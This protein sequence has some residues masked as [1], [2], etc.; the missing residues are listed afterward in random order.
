M[1]I[2]LKSQGRKQPLDQVRRRKALYL[3]GAALTALM[4][5]MA[6]MSP[7]LAKE[8]DP[9]GVPYLEFVVLYAASGAV[10]LAAFWIVYKTRA[11]WS[12]AV[13]VV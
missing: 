5:I 6:L 4:G 9:A 3:L 2:V 8:S 13:I 12:I 1:N 7:D 10:F 11:S